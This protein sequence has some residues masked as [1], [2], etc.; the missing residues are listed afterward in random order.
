M[1]NDL[2][3]VVVS[4]QITLILSCITFIVDLWYRRKRIRL[5]ERK[6]RALEKGGYTWLER[7]KLNEPD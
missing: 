6:I 3:I 4:S 1:V 2:I 5:E 7:E